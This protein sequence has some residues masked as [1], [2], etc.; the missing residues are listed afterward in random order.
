MILFSFNKSAVPLS[1]Y[2][3]A[4]YRA[5]VEEFVIEI[6]K[7]EFTQNVLT[8]IK[9]NK[10]LPGLISWCLV[11]AV[12]VCQ[13]NIKVHTALPPPLTAT[14]QSPG[15]LCEHITHQGASLQNLSRNEKTYRKTKKGLEEQFS[16]SVYFI[17]QLFLLR[18]Y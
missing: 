14:L 5:E 16:E 13:A 8:L 9:K 18:V 3:T 17:Q 2:S 7:T 15:Y 1:I 4:R 11:L 12:S 6:G 10:V